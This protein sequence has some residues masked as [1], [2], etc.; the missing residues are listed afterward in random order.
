MGKIQSTQSL[1]VCSSCYNTIKGNIGLPY[2]CKP[3]MCVC[4]EVLICKKCSSL[5]KG[6]RRSIIED[7]TS[8]G[9]GCEHCRST[10]TLLYEIS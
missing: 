6:Q 4:N 5:N 9:N 1:K 8:R 10:P 3:P 7:W 2:G